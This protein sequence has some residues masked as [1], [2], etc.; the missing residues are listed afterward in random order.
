[1]S[2]SIVI[3]TYNERDNIQELLERTHRSMEP[4]GTSYELIIV[5]DDSPDKTWELASQYADA[6]HVRTVRR[7]GKRGL[8]TAVLEGFSAARYDIIVVMDADLQHPP[9]KV[10]LLLSCVQ[11]GADIAVGNRF[12]ENGTSAGFSFLGYTASKAAGTLA[13][14]L[15]REVRNVKDIESG[16]FAFK[17]DII[18]HADLRPIGYKILLELLVQGSYSTVTEVGYTFGK[19][20]AGASKLGVKN[21]VAY[22]RHISSLF[23]RSGEF[24]RFAQFCAVGGAGAVLNL[25]LLYVLTELGMFYGAA[26]LI[27]IEVGLL[28]NFVLN[29]SWTFKDRGVAGFKSTMAALGR[30]H[31]VRVVG[32]I[33]NLAILLILTS[34]FGVFYLLSQLIGLIVGMVWNYGGNQWWTW[35]LKP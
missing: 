1:M 4:L 27:A 18:A 11:N 13:R 12:I 15:F 30:D 33:L 16:F 31:A 26:G 20:E 14:T 2:A 9:E 24:R 19:R 8:A 3:P 5:D 34:L 29:R 10:P 7:R 28:S 17:K 23:Y 21:S 25:A 6:Y 32:I 22:L 35:E